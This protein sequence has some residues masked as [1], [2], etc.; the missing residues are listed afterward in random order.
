MVQSDGL[1]DGVSDR[2]TGIIKRGRVM[3]R[4][5]AI[6]KRM[7]ELDESYGILYSCRNY[8]E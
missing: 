4:G 3:E 2:T 1:I 6:E 8:T 5:H 7:F